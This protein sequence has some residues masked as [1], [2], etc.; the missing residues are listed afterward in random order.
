MGT[1]AVVVLPP[2]GLPQ[3]C[4]GSHWALC[5]QAGWGAELCSWAL[6]GAD[7]Q[8]DPPQH[9]PG[10]LTFNLYCFPA[11]SNELEERTGVGAGRF[12]L[13]AAQSLSIK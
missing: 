6:Q 10:G 4:E 13:I 3:I 11:F 1:G 2:W 7:P 9:S 5:S 8:P 12:C